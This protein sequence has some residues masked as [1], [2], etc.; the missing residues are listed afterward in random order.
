MFNLTTHQGNANQNQNKLSPHSSKKEYS[1][2]TEISSALEDVEKRSYIYYWWQCKLVYHYGR[3][4]RSSSKIK[5]G[6]SM[7][8]A[9]H[10][11]YTPMSTAS[12]LTIAKKR[13]QLST[14]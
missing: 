12:L 3:Q 10:G 13:K 9:C 11:V 7:K 6:A 4:H 5:T 1:Q 8:S 2:K 14:N